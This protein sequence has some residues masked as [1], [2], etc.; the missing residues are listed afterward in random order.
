MS[1]ANYRNYLRSEFEVRARANTRYSLNAFARDLGL[2]PS[3]LS[4]ILNEKQGMSRE[5]AA[6]IAGLIGL[7]PDESERFCDMVDLEHARSAERRQLAKIRLEHREVDD[8]YWM[9]QND[10]FQLMSDWYHFAIVQLVELP[11]FR[12]DGRWIAR[13]LRISRGEAEGAVARLLRLGVL[14][15]TKSGLQKTKD[16]MAT[17]DGVPSG[18]IR[19]FHA[20]V[21]DKA[22]IALGEQ[23]VENR[24]YSVN[25]LTIDKAKLPQ[26]KE[27]MKRFRRRFVSEISSGTRKESVYCLSQQ[28][29]ELTPGLEEK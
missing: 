26:A 5:V 4:E 14:Q 17:T 22:L 20:Q 25:F 8:S 28:L 27:M 19:K 15:E 6:R 3:R 21:L 10:V 16:F 18:A 24:N 7:R 2:S 12:H 1:H 23:T 13:A 9:L 11:N 29:F